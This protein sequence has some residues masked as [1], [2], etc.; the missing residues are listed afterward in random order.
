MNPSISS[1]VVSLSGQRITRVSMPARRSL[2]RAWS[3]NCFPAWSL[4]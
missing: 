2:R 1:F 4:S 3:V